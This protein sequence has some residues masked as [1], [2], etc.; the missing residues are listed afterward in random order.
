MKRTTVM[1]DEGAYAELESY[2]RRDGVSTGHLIR[3]AMERY[4]T[5]RERREAA[6]PVPLPSFVGAVDDP[7]MVQGA[8]V[9][10]FLEAWLPTHEEDE[11]NG[12][13][14]R[15]GGGDHAGRD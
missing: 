13:W 4:L 3:E 1:L 6:A 12:P 11:R 14:A 9:E 15:G 2:A 8:D 10:E 7:D 5:D